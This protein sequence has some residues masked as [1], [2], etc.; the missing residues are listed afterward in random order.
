M[1]KYEEQSVPY[2]GTNA[3]G[4][5][6]SIHTRQLVCMFNVVVHSRCRQ[7][8]A[9]QSLERRRRRRTG[10]TLV[11]R[12]E[13]A[14]VSAPQKPD[15]PHGRASVALRTTISEACS[16]TLSETEMGWGAT[17]L[18]DFSRNQKIIH[19]L[20]IYTRAEG[21]EQSVMV[22]IRAETDSHYSPSVT[23][24]KTWNR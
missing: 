19:L 4:I 1:H 18:R 22:A 7:V 2:G 21:G 9:V 12:T 17:L 14:V 23:S 13:W 8:Y 11:E 10:S 16:P 5:S 15:R 6:G 3:Q 24:H 20:R